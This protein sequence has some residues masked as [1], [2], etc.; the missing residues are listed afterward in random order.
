[1][2]GS[3]RSHENAV[4]CHVARPDMAVDL[5]VATQNKGIGRQI[6]DQIAVK[7]DNPSTAQ[8]SPDGDVLQNRA[9]AL[10]KSPTRGILGSKA[11]IKI[12]CALCEHG[13]VFQTV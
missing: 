12:S 2:H 11:S 5:A 8:V 10:A 13:G 3:D 9:A 4:N 7:G 6:A 1:M